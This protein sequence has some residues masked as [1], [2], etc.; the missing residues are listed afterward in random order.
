M[1]KESESYN[2]NICDE[3]VNVAMSVD[4]CISSDIIPD[5][6][7]LRIFIKRDGT[8]SCSNTQTDCNVS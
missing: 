5:E 8:D 1:L 4:L 6:D 2:S 3:L 7:L